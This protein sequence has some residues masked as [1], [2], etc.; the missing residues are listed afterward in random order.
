[1]DNELLPCPFDKYEEI[2]DQFLK[3]GWH[4]LNDAQW[5]HLKVWCENMKVK[6]NHR[7]SS[8]TV[9][10]DQFVTLSKELEARG[11]DRT[12]ITTIV[13]AIECS[14]IMGAS[15]PGRPSVEEIMAI[16]NRCLGEDKYGIIGKRE[17][18]K[19]IVSRFNPVP[20][21]A[22]DEE[23][24]IE[25]LKELLLKPKPLNNKP[26]IAELEQILNGP[27]GHSLAMLP[28]GEI[29]MVNPK[30]SIEGIGRALAAKFPA[31]RPLEPL[32]ER[33]LTKE[34]TG[35]YEQKHSGLLFLNVETFIKA[36]CA[37]FGAAR[38]AVV[39]EE[40]IFQAMWKVE[41]DFQKKKDWWNGEDLKVFMRKQAKAVLE[42]IN[43]T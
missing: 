31:A 40:D 34:A 30:I 22:L 35:H 10:Q 13:H 18:A 23:A 14:G 28:N 16:L 8:P 24:V 4:S 26:T 29:A 1:M 3:L 5:E 17:A 39:T 36:I 9:T 43:K 20:G 21:L 27:E 33:E 25:F 12:E 7:A 41:E 32:D 6:W 15:A 2:A 11:F 19:E 37:K 38:P 42:R